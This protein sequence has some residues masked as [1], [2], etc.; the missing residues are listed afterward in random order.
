MLAGNGRGVYACAMT[1]RPDTIA[2]IVAAGAG[3]RAGGNVPKQYRMIGDKPVLAHAIDAMARHSAIEAIQV[4]IGD[5][6]QDDYASAIHPRDLRAAVVGGLERQHSVRLGLEAIAA[7]GEAEIVLIHD[8][9]RPFC[10][11][12]VIDRLLAALRTHQGAVPALPAVDSLA[13]A[14]QLLGDPVSR[15]DIVRVQTPQAFRFDA[16]LA[17]HR[18]WTRSERATDDAQVA[19]AAGIEIAVVEG[20]PAL[21]KLTFAGDFE[22]SAMFVTRTGLGFDVHAFAP[23]DRLWLGGIEIAHHR[24][25]T[26]HSDADVVLHALTDAILGA[27][28]DGDIGSHFPPGDPQWRAAASHL[29]LDHARALVAARGGRIDHVDVT[30]ICETPRIGPHRAAMTARIAQIL[31]ISIASVSVKATTTERLGFIGRD[32]GIAAQAIATIRLPG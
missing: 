17:A 32:E 10:P 18:G 19:R 2:L 5:G 14:G 26:G 20:D 1:D 21:E 16:I 23:G 29:F 3:A 11:L 27:L 7:A 4:V 15:D 25:L 22:R 31:A 30:V 12:A 9:A 28:G 6:Q 8:A 13:R 24:A